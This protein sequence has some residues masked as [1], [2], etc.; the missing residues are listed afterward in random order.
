MFMIITSLFQVEA[1]HYLVGAWKLLEER[2]IVYQY[3]LCLGPTFFLTFLFY[4]VDTNDVLFAICFP[5]EL[6]QFIY[7]SQIITSSW[8]ILLHA[9]GEN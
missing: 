3:Y 4:C 6:H 7:E 8:C 2:Y 9:L 1:K 5:K